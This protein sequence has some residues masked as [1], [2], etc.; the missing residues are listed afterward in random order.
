MRFL[1]S[2]THGMLDYLTGILLIV[3]P[4][5]FD[6]AQMGAETWVPVIVGITIILMSVFTSYELGLIRKIPLKTH[7]IV[8]V[9]T[10]LFLA[11]SPWIF[12]FAEI[13][14]WPHVLFGVMEMAAGL[15]TKTKPDSSTAHHSPAV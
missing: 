12:D 2:K 1:D 15:V 8:D 14:Y 13:I 3:A 10:G 5:L 11:L 9:V 6:F 4:W 7:L